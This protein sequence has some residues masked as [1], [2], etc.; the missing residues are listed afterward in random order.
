M[1]LVLRARFSAANSEKRFS[2]VHVLPSRSVHSMMY[3]PYCFFFLPCVR[4]A[5]PVVRRDGA[6]S[7]IARDV[8]MLRGGGCAAPSLKAFARPRSLPR[9]RRPPPRTRSGAAAARRRALLAGS[10][11]RERAE[12]VR[13]GREREEGGAEGRGGGGREWG[14]SQGCVRRSAA[15][16]EGGARILAAATYSY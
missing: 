6:S 8:C 4:T 15:A 1:H 16:E 12:K 3:T 9:S 2:T 7:G 11:R 5:V 14:K 13:D 10:G